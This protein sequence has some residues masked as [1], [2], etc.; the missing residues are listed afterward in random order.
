MSTEGFSTSRVVIAIC[1]VGIA[2]R[3]C[4]EPVVEIEDYDHRT[5]LSERQTEALE[6]IADSLEGGCEDAGTG[7]L[8]EGVGFGPS[9]ESL[10]WSLWTHDGTSLPFDTIITIPHEAEL[11]Q[12]WAGESVFT[13]P[14]Q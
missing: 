5:E 9:L 13:G 8:P 11:L 7:P 2:L 10:G 6:R 14:A 12:R 4:S 1:V 3:V